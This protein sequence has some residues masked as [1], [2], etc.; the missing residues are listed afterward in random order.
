MKQTKK[1][2]DMRYMLIC[3][4]TLSR[5]SSHDSLDSR[6]TELTRELNQKDSELD[7]EVDDIIEA[8]R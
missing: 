5:L 3:N 1:E 8:D 7:Q 4:R 6:L 2:M